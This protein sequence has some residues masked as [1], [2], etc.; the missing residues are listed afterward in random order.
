MTIPEAAR[1]MR[2]RW[3]IV[4]EMVRSERLPAIVRGNRR[5]VLRSD[6]D[7]MIQKELDTADQ[8]RNERIRRRRLVVTEFSDPAFRAICERAQVSSNPRHCYRA[9]G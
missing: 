1:Y 6:V 8:R 2:R 9:S 4:Y 5:Y 3:L 7:R